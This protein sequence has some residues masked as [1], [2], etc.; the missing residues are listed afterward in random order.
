MQVLVPEGCCGEC[1]VLALPGDNRIFVC[2]RLGCPGH[3][4]HIVE[5]P[6]SIVAQVDDINFS[7]EG[8]PDANYFSGQTD[9]IFRGI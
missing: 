4:L 8:I 5:M 2:A 1:I 3:Q 6:E 7:P 9:D